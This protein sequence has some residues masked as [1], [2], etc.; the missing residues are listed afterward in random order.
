MSLRISGKNIEIGDAYRVHVESRIGA[1]LAKYFD[2]GFSGRVVL[3]RDGAGYRVDC[4]L[5]LDSGVDLKSEGRGHDIYP[6]FDQAAERIDKQL[7][8]YKRRLKDHHHEQKN[9]ADASY[10]VLAA[11]PEDD[12]EIELDYAPVVI[13]EEST[14]LKTLSVS[15][16]VMAMDLTDA[17]VIVFRH[18]AHGGVNVV[19]RRQDGNI[20]WI[21]PASAGK[22]DS[23]DR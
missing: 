1:T 3:E 18:A 17:P 6:T 9:G 19:Y 11:T 15:S 20:G 22:G 16:A 4:A 13:A 21:D 8:R 14:R 23:V 10:V 12:E 7:R 2:G 5:H